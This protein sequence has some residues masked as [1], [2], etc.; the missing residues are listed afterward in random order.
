ME[1]HKIAFSGPKGNGPLITKF[2]EQSGGSE[3]KLIFSGHSCIT[4]GLTLKVKGLKK[5]E[6]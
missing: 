1:A 3:T 5:K 2:S 6:N 4:Y